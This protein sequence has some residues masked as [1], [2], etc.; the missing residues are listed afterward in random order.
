MLENYHLYLKKNPLQ[1]ARKAIKRYQ[2]FYKYTGY[3]FNL[4]LI[5]FCA[6]FEMNVISLVH[7][8][9]AT[10]L[11]IYSYLIN[12]ARSDVDIEEEGIKAETE[13]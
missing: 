12:R 10:Y 2:F 9:I 3:E 6:Y 1:Q 8:G 7:I 13:E 4:F 11:S 5:I